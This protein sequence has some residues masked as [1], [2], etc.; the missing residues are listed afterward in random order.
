MRWLFRE[1][2]TNSA[3]AFRDLADV[4]MRL[5]RFQH[6]AAALDAMDSVGMAKAG[7]S[8]TESHAIRTMRFAEVERGR[9]DDLYARLVQPKE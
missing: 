3:E 8:A 2:G 6:V 1:R 7:I 4:G 5:E 9:L